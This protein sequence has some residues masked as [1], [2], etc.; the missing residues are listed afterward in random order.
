MTAVISTILGV[1]A[2][3]FGLTALILVQRLRST[4]E[5]ELGN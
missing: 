1:I 2:F 5:S 4:V 3:A